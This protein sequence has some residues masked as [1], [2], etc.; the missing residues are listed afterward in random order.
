[1]FG[2][3]PQAH[4]TGALLLHTMSNVEL[5]RDGF[6]MLLGASQDNARNIASDIGIIEPDDI[7]SA[8][9]RMLT[10]DVRYGF[11]M[12][13]D[14]RATRV[15]GRSELNAQTDRIEHRRVNRPAGYGIADPVQLEP[16]VGS[17]AKRG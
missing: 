12:R 16:I 14:A 17:R 9:A 13:L 1:M 11:V 2:S 8:F 5:R 6:P 7:E 3:Y 4:D 15:I 10:G